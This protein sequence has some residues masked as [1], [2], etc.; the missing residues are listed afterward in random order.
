M[1]TV[2]VRWPRLLI[3]AT[4]AAVV[5]CYAG[6]TGEGVPKADVLVGE[7]GDSESAPLARRV[8]VWEREPRPYIVILESEKTS[9]PPSPALPEHRRAHILCNELVTD[10]PTAEAIFKE[11][12]E[13][14]RA[15]ID[16]WNPDC[17][18]KRINLFLWCDKS[19]YRTEY[20]QD[21]TAHAMT[22]LAQKTLPPWPAPELTW[23]LLPMPKAE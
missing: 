14:F 6:P 12:Y 13:E 5:G 23:N 7:G 20:G 4:L 1:E 21:F 15:D 22:G 18:Y 10:R 9:A 11:V 19:L 3:G 17:R 8:P 2:R 16:G